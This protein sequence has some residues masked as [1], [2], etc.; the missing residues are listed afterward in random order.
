MKMMTMKKSILNRDRR[1]ESKRRGKEQTP[2]QHTWPGAGKPWKGQEK[3][4]AE[5]D[6]H[7]TRPEDGGD[8]S[9]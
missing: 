6:R 9:A 2:T 4:K 8:G 1:R 7:G 5:A 3:R